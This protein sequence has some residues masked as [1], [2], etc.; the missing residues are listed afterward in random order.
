MP[1]G[2][3]TYLTICL[4]YSPGGVMSKDREIITNDELRVRFTAWL[5][6]VVK[7]TKINYMKR[8]FRI[9]NEISLD[10]IKES[11]LRDDREIDIADISSVTLEF[12]DNRIARAFATLSKTRQRILTM[13]FVQGMNAE[14]I[15]M[16]LN[17]SV[18]NVYNQRSHALKQL[19]G[20]LNDKKNE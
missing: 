14:E 19:K 13:L 3:A 7:R 20:L 11:E 1:N 18:Q 2:M 5:T 8:A 15:A 16:Q 4:R 6:V 9:R 17:C 12:S 10:S